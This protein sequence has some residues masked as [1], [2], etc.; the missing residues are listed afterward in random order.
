M[1]RRAGR[2]N[3]LT[4]LLVGGLAA[5]GVGV[6][7]FGPYYLDY[8]NMKEITA[9]SALAWYANVEKSS[10]LQRFDRG[11]GERGIDYNDQTYCDFDKDRDDNIHI[12]CEWE[13]YCYY[14]FTEYYKTL[15]FSVDTYVDNRGNLEQY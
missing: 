5:I 6:A 10:A 7:T 2:A 12:Y 15:D 1:K 13:A 11:L 4:I 3:F 9:S 14:P 8:L